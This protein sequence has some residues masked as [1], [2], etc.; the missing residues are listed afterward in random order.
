MLDELDAILMK[1]A[2]NADSN[3][4]RTTVLEIIQEI[5]LQRLTLE[6]DFY[7]AVVQAFHDFDRGKSSLSKEEGSTGKLGQLSLVDKDDFEITVEIT[8]IVTNAEDQFSQELY[9]LNHR[10]AVINGGTKLGERNAA[11]PSGPVHLCEAFLTSIDSIALNLELKIQLLKSFQTYV[12]NQAGPIYDEFNASLARAGVLPNLTIGDA[13]SSSYV[14]KERKLP[15]KQ[16]ENRP[17]ATLDRDSAS[18]GSRQTPRFR[19]DE[20][21]VSDFTGYY[22]E[23]PEDEDLKQA[24]FQGIS[25]ILAQR[26][27]GQ[28]LSSKQIRP[29]YAGTVI[30]E[31][32]S[33]TN[34]AELVLELNSLQQT[35]IPQVGT[36]NLNLDAIR[37][38]FVLQIEKLSEILQRQQVTTADADMIDLVGMLF[39]MILEDQTLPD[40]VKALLSHL[41]T[42]FLKIAVLDKKFFVRGQHPARRLLNALSQAGS[43]CRGTDSSS[44][45]ILLKMRDVVHKI[46]KNFQDNTEMFSSLLEE[47]NGF[48]AADRRRAMM[49]EQRTVEAARGREKLQSARHTVSHEIVERL[50]S[51]S[52]PNFVE[53]LLM[54]A[55]ANYLVIT[56]LRAG[57]NSQ[58]WLSVLETTDELIWSVQPKKNEDER[59]LLRVKLPALVETVKAG[60]EISGD[61]ESDVETILMNL[62][63]CH[64]SVLAIRKKV[65]P[66][67]AKKQRPNSLP[68]HA[69]ISGSVPTRELS[70]EDRLKQWKEIIPKEWQEDLSENVIN[71]PAEI[72]VGPER[73]A[74]LDS[75]QHLEFGSWFEFFDEEKKIHTRGKLAWINKTTSKLLFVNQGGRQVAVRL[76]SGFADDLEQGRAKRIEPETTPFVDK[77]LKSIQDLLNKQSI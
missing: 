41:H 68:Q 73:Q 61:I 18:A 12:V 5:Q 15:Q 32:I 10:L 65:D 51:R 47:F 45:R 37:D 54:G 23:S 33:T 70:T 74:L 59:S 40:A 62:E 8:G 19:S 55:W 3:A 52:L 30:Q 44:H 28:R 21:V 43:L 63:D 26:T 27:H 60:L 36:T 38:S 69:G 72:A 6:Q 77:A 7:H 42:P 46:V 58:E 4:S 53:S 39:E 13:G 29:G 34:L 11:L 76:L 66:L 71:Q 2:D 56:L 50:S 67:S 1:V 25:Q 22:R 17:A 31:G 48:M 9:A 20:Q 64:R 24:L 16:V 35:S 57:E 49:I 75:L 14:I